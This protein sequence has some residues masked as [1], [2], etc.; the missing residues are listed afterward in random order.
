MYLITSLACLMFRRIDRAVDAFVLQCRE[1]IFGHTVVPAPRYV[2]S[3]TASPNRPPDAETHPRCT[4]QVEVVDVFAAFAGSLSVGGAALD[5]S[6][7]IG[8]MATARQR[9]RGEGYIAEGRGDGARLITGWALQ[10]YP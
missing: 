1:E 10:R 4:D 9:E 6:T 3:R 5:P 2:P 8:P 7:Q